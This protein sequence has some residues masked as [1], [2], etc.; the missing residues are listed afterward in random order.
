M[1]NENTKEQIVFTYGQ[2]VIWDTNPY[3]GEGNIEGN[4]VGIDKDGYL[5]I[6]DVQGY[7]TDEINPEDVRIKTHPLDKYQYT[8]FDKRF[9]EVE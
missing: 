6:K 4:V 7:V 9:T 1:T 2:E 3:T 8:L 5:T